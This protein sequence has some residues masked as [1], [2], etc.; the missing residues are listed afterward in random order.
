M[1]PV[2]NGFRLNKAGSDSKG[3]CLI[4]ARTYELGV[5]FGKGLGGEWR[6]SHVGAQSASVN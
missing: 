4:Y 1:L 2:E 6:H 5:L 3:Y